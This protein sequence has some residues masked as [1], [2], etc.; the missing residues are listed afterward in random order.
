MAMLLNLLNASMPKLIAE[1]LALS[2]GIHLNTP[3]Q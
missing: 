3:I 2:T 1:L